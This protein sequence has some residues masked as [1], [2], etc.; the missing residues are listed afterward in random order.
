VQD[1]ETPH[2][3]LFEH[4]AALFASHPNA[5]LVAPGNEPER[6]RRVRALAGPEVPLLVPGVGAQG[7]DAAT[8][9]G[10]AGAGPM[11]VSASRSISGAKGRFPDAQAKAA[12]QLA[13]LL[14]G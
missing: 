6:L 4:V 5:G 2:G 13:K 7:G 11:L 3:P 1:L 10:A 14:Q 8:V 9:R 12:E